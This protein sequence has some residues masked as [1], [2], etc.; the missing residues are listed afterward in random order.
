MAAAACVRFRS[1]PTRPRLP[2]YS[3]SSAIPA[4]TEARFES[5]LMENPTGSPASDLQTVE[6]VRSG[7]R[8]I[9]HGLEAQLYG[10]ALWPAGHTPGP[11]CPAEGLIACR[12]FELILTGEGPNLAARSRSLGGC[13]S[14]MRFLGLDETRRPEG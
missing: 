2:G 10:G 6:I 11:V 7:L 12:P 1:N 3:I 5:I 8:F 14:R 13:A 4:G 9:F